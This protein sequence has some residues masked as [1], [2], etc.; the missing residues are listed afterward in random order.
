MNRRP[1][2]FLVCTLAL[3][4]GLLSGCASAPGPAAAPTTAPPSPAVPA[5]L[6]P[7]DPAVVLGRLPNGFRYAIR[8]NGRPEERA[9]LWLVL[10]AGSMQEDDDQRGLA[11]FVEHMAFNGTTHFA[12]QE[13][14]DFLES[15]G[16]KFGPD[17]NAYTSF[18]ETVYMLQVPTDD[19]ELL[20]KS[21]GILQ[22]WAEGITFEAEE[23]D[24]ERGVVLEEW[25]LGQGAA[26]RIRDQQWPVLFRGSLYAE[27]LPIGDEEIIQNAPHDVL[28]RFYRD[29]YR[30]DLMA[31]VAVGDFD[32]AWME[33]QIRRRFR[34]LKG[35]ED[36]RPRLLASVPDHEETL[37][38]V[39]TDPET[40]STS[41]SVYYKLEREE[42]LTDRD[43]RRQI[44]SDLHH[45][46][47]QGRLDEVRRRPDPPFLFASTS[48]GEFVRARNVYTQGVV[49]EEGGA[50]RGLHALLTEVERVDR[51]GFTATELARQKKDTLRVFEQV[52]RER[53]KRRS[54]SL[55]RELRDHFLVAEPVPGIEYERDLVE[56]LLPEITLREVNALSREWIRDESRVVLFSGPESD[57]PPPSEMELLAA[58]ADVRDQEIEPYVDQ[59]RLGPLV[60]DPPAGGTVVSEAR[61]E[62]ID[63]TEWELSN[64]ARVILKPTTFKNDEIFLTAFSPG[65]TSLAG[66]EAYRSAVVAPALIGAGGLGEFGLVELDKA[67]AGKLAAA[68]VSIGELEESVS[69]RASPEDL[70]TM[71]ELLYLRFTAPRRDDEAIESWMARQRAFLKNREASPGVAFNDE[72]VRVLTGDHPRRRPWTVERMEEIDPGRALE[73]YR[74][75][76]ADASDFTFVLVGSFQ[77]E[78]IRPLVARWIGGLPSTRREET[79]AD[80]GIQ[81]PEG[82]VEVDV[83]RGLEPKSQVQIIFQGPAEWS[84]QSLHDI[85]SLASTLRIR[86]REVL[87]EDM[88]P[89]TGSASGVASPGGRSRASSS[90]SG[91]GAR[92]RMSRNWCRPP[93]RRW[94]R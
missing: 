21:L 31:L 3:L 52:Y 79:W 50:T 41:V 38:A 17:I 46:M 34:A 68:G 86:L 72:M 29:W 42:F 59:V 15:I 44:V 27:R 66:D 55:A 56:R 75:R 9:L 32:S 4:I 85:R 45:G 91:S 11:H 54:S 51:F 82:V 87:R 78:A 28:R 60:E 19:R 33:E 90:A 83:H 22:D 35:P 63:V 64:G 84:R 39:V 67:L 1:S 14:V 25:R 69:G 6:L 62:E 92:R 77:P 30:P 65:G 26:S 94:R 89:P 8:E 49:V 23:I 74:D 71:F 81:G 76:F 37:F 20:E 48:S 80:I 88:G 13:L 40:T 57:T 16:M 61:V 58:L 7:F 18:D 47:L 73:F 93:S 53:D 12:K 24:K 70:E 43:Y 5:D 2:S 10:D 36:P